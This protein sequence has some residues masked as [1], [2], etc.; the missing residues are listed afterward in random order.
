M[1]SNHTVKKKNILS[2]WKFKHCGYL[3]P[4]ICAGLFRDIFNLMGNKHQWTQRLFHRLKWPSFLQTVQSY[5]P[6]PTQIFKAWSLGQLYFDFQRTECYVP[7]TML[8][9][10]DTCKSDF[11]CPSLL[12][13]LCRWLTQPLT[14]I[15]TRNLPGGVKDEQRVSWQPYSHLWAQLS[16]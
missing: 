2:S 12:H 8:H 15:S 11:L 9:R 10:M 4:I 14:D 6:T 16:R 5:K 3:T 7:S 13:I 1:Q